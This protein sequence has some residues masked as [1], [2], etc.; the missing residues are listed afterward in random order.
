MNIGGRIYQNIYCIC[1]VECSDLDFFDK[2][3]QNRMQ[4]SIPRHIDI[5]RFSFFVAFRAIVPSKPV[6]SDDKS[7]KNLIGKNIWVSV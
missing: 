6:K 5:R 1:R 7:Q 4:N 2:I 3:E